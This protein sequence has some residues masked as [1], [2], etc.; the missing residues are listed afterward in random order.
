MIKLDDSRLSDAVAERVRVSHAQA[1]R[2]MQLLPKVIKGVQ[3]VDTVVKLVPHKLDRAPEI[4]LVSP[5]RGA[6]SAG[7]IVEITDIAS[8]NPDR[9]K[10]VALKASGMGAT[11]TVDVEVR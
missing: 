4:V 11:V 7:V 10:Y 3:L 9:A 8:G 6:T 5:P 2:E 1:I